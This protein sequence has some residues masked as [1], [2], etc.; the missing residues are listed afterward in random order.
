MT[1]FANDHAFKEL[2]NV[3][4]LCA[5]SL[6]FIDNYSLKN[7]L[8]FQV[9]MF[10]GTSEIPNQIQKTIKDDSYSI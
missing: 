4:V 2:R 3:S 8:S 1:T 10:L 7:Q 5:L 6:Y 9:C